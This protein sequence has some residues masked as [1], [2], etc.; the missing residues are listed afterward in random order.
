MKFK[1]SWQKDKAMLAPDELA[2]LN[3]LSFSDKQ[4][5]QLIAIA[6]PILSILVSVKSAKTC[7][8]VE[9]LR[10]NIISLINQFESQGAE[11]GCS[12]RIIL[13]ARYCLCTALDAAVLS[14][15]WGINST[16][17]GKSLLAILHNETWGG[18]RFYIILQRIAEESHSNIDFLELMY[19]ILSLGFEGKFF[20]DKAK[21]DEIRDELYSKIAAYRP[22]NTSMLLANEETQTKTILAKRYFLPVWIPIAFVLNL[23]FVVN[24][25]YQYKLNALADQTMI[26][27][28]SFRNSLLQ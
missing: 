20:N 21:R 15:N 5:N 12:A 1:R 8:D 27:V 25:F 6:M 11:A 18:E 3:D 24:F 7:S 19:L 2:E 9:K 22:N 26:K 13:A 14:T 10:G 4:D 23:F 28:T 16:W 17:A